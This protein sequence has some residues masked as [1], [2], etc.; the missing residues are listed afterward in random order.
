M[1]KSR[2]SHTI[3]VG[4]FIILILAVFGLLVHVLALK[5][6][7][8]SKSDQANAAQENL[9]ISTEEIKIYLPEICYATVGVPLE[10]YNSQITDQY[11]NISKYNVCWKCDIGENLERKYSLNATEDMV[12]EY[13]ITVFIYDNALNLLAEKKSQLKVADTIQSGQIKAEKLF[14]Q[15]NNVETVKE[16]MTNILEKIEVIRSAD[17]EISIYAAN[18]CYPADDDVHQLSQELEKELKKYENVYFVPAQISLD[19]EY[20]YD[21]AQ[22]KLNEAGIAQIEDL[23]TAVIYGTNE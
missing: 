3:I 2:K 22:A 8:Q 9:E 13:E 16:N 7:L 20:N 1:R 23:F 15:A 10:I 17:P 14:F 18:V 5:K 12:G 21:T 11:D 19:W 6:E 4:I